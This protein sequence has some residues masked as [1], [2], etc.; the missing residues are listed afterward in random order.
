MPRDN[1]QGIFQARQ[2]IQDDV[3]QNQCRTADLCIAVRRLA[4][5][6]GVKG[7]AGLIFEATRG[8]IRI[9][10]E[11]WVILLV[12]LVSLT[13]HSKVIHVSVTYTERA[14]WENWGTRMTYGYSLASRLKTP[15]IRSQVPNI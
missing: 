3:E 12:F 13:I 8:I 14:E 4:R 2:A 15:S 5:R 9:F 1:I 10:I 11:K 7:I 6:G